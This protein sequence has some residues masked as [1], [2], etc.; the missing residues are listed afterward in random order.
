MQPKQPFFH[1]E[2]KKLQPNENMAP[3]ALIAPALE[4]FR[5]DNVPI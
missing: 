4:R 1:H 5:V 2:K 3:M